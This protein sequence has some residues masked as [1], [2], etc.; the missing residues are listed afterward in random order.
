MFLFSMPVFEQGVEEG[1]ELWAPWQDLQLRCFVFFLGY[2][3]FEGKERK[4]KERKGK[5]LPHFSGASLYA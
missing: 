1:S 3:Y 5:G 2:L 4:G